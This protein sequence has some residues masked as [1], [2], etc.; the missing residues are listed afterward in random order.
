MHLYLHNK[1][2]RLPKLKDEFK[3]ITETKKKIYVPYLK[4]VKEIFNKK[5]KCPIT[6]TKKTVL[7][8]CSLSVSVKSRPINGTFGFSRHSSQRSKNQ[9]SHFFASALADNRTDK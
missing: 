4:Y 9:K 2:Y 1:N 5:N 3:N 7:V 6:E 8:T